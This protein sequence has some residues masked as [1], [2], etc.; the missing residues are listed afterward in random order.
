MVDITGKENSLRYAKAFA[1]IECASQTIDKLKN[2]LVPK[3]DV[4]EA[5]RVAA[6]FGMKKTPELIPDCHPLPI[7]YGS[8][9]Y[10]ILENKVEIYVEAK[11]YYK[12]GLEVEAMTGASIAA[13]TMY[14]MLKPI[15]KS[16]VIRDIQLLEK[17]GGKSGDIRREIS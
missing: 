15:D 14:D 1:R 6:L 13:L 16:V 8:V 5:A 2:N 17:S 3:G 12:T 11:T 7:E 4:L 9:S 10:T